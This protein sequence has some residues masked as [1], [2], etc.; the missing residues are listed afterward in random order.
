MERF[1]FFGKEFLTWL[2]FVCE[3]RDGRIEVQG[4]GPV[5]IEIDTKIELTA[6]GDHAKAAV[7]EELP[8]GSTEA[9]AA[10]R[11][12]KKLTK[13]NFRLNLEA[14]GFVATLDEHLRMSG[15]KLPFGLDAK[16]ATDQDQRHYVVSDRLSKLDELERLI[17]SMFA[18][19]VEVRT[20]AGWA[21]E[22][23]AMCEWVRSS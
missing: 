19:F 16:E 17:E 18:I 21:D 14:H 13:A 9:H 15:V 22:N 3:T 2:W 12:G 10:L 11:V 8:T 7:T 6:A 20:G 1:S 23:E 5:D 4:F